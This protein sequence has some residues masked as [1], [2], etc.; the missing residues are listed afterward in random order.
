[1]GG[2]FQNNRIQEADFVV[3]LAKA[4]EIPNN[5]VYARRIL[6]SIFQTLRVRIT[7]IASSAIIA[8]LSK[9]VK[10]MYMGGWDNRYLPMFDYDDFINALYKQKGLEH[11]TLFN[12]K[13]HAERSV[14]AIFEV[15]K[16]QLTDNQYN[17][18]MSLMPVLLR[19]NLMKDYV[20][21]GH[22]YFS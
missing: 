11:L 2:V 14:A 20:F 4:L 9:D 16:V 10:Q 3:Q 6:C 13:Q 21:E 12:S 7:P 5:T 22:S 1:M 18:M 17:S 15:M 19:L 8:H